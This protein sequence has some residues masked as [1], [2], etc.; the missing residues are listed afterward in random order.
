[1]EDAYEV[2]ITRIL[3]S[4]HTLNKTQCDVNFVKF[5]KEMYI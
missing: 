5:H 2:K 4:F 1:M 3:H